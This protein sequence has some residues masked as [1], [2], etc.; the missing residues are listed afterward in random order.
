MLGCTFIDNTAGAWGGALVAGG[1]ALIRDCIFEGNATTDV[2][3]GYGGAVSII[4]LEDAASILNCTFLNNTS[5]TGGG[6]SVSKYTIATVINCTFCGNE[7]HTGGGLGLYYAETVTLIN[8]I[9]ADSIQGAAVGGNGTIVLSHCN[10]FGNAGGDWVGDIAGQLGIDGNICA[11]PLF[12]DSAQSDCHLTYLSPCRNTGDNTPAGLPVEDFEGDPRIAQ[13][14]VDMGAD[15]FNAHLYVTGN[16][17]PEG[18]V[19][20]NFVGDPGSTPMALFI[21]FDVF[22]PPLP[23]KWGDFYIKPPRILIPL[24]PIPAGGILTIRTTLPAMSGPY[25]VALQALIGDALSNLEML[26]VR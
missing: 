24:I 7:A 13:D 8:C 21:G 25:D 11:D 10:L 16:A 14:L 15:E 17:V 3:K 19:S 20:G 23:T 1:P 2:T 4:A 6:L 18:R 26:C 12:V 22:D 5:G 9:I